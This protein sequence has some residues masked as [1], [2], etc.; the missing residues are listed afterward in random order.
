MFRHQSPLTAIQ[1]GQD[2]V[3]RC[4]RCAWEV[5]DGMCG[6]CGWN[7]PS[8]NASTFSVNSDGSYGINE[9]D[10]SI[11]FDARAAHDQYLDDVG[12]F[13]GHDPADF[14]GPED[15]FDAEH[16]QEYFEQMQLHHDSS[17]NTD[18]EEDGSVGKSEI[19]AF[20]AF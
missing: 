12:A 10:E 15:A 19:E 1:D 16:N 8:E 2:G 5:V 14:H 18:S 17:F 7:D 11:G 9:D 3:L 6:S 20:A 4:P 13:L